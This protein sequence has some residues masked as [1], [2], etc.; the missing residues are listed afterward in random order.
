MVEILHLLG[1]GL[2]V[3]PR[4]GNQNH[5]C[6]RQI[7][8]A[9][10]HKFQGIVHHS[11]VGPLLIDDGQNLV[12]LVLKERGLHGFLP[13]QHLVHIAPDGVDLPVVDNDPVWVGPHPTGIG[14]G[15]EP[16]VNRGQGGFIILVLEIGKELPKL[17]HQKHSLVH[18]GPAA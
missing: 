8:A 13:G 7:H 2:I 1:H 17:L 3:L 12:H 18:N 10:H 16:G 9:H 15:T 11:R 4:C 6:Q 14:V 5:H